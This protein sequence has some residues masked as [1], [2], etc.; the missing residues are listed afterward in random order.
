MEKRPL[1]NTQIMV[2]KLCFGAL[3]IGPLQRNMP[4]KQGA[5][6]IRH[7]LEMGINFIDTAE[8]YNTYDYIREA[9]KG[10]EGDVVI[11]SK[12]YAY[13]YEGMKRSLKS[14]LDSLN[15]KHIDIFLLHEQ[16]S[17]LTFKGHSDAYRCLIDA[18]KAGIIRACGI[19]THHVAM[20]E[21]AAGCEEIDVVHPLLNLSGIGIADGT[22]RQ[23][24]TAI[25]NLA[26]KGKG[27]Y[28]MK[29]LGGGN[30]IPNYEAAMSYALNVEGVA[31]VAVGMASKAEV[32]ANILFAE[33][34]PIP[35]E[36]KLMLS[37]QKRRLLIEGW[38]KGCGCCIKR[39]T[40]NALSL[41]N[42][43]VYVD[44]DKCALCGYC[45]AACPDFCIKVI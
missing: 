14:A 6:I 30:L 39:C 24:E 38:C 43:R 3:T 9:I 13:T 23:M 16:E 22:A 36:L 19:S 4:V 44:Q 26:L 21:F 8:Y 33:G 37:R 1:G 17:G 15:V 41:R 10:Y 35:G 12:S 29:P 32:E 5:S 45:A 31:S 28:L 27:I 25:K 42:G 2:S 18:K 20:A 11:A 7:A 34:R 40:N